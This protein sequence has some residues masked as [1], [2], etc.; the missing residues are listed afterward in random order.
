M[1]H[2]T[3][4]PSHTFNARNKLKIENHLWYASDVVFLDA[5]VFA[6]PFMILSFRYR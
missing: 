4:I 5:A 1:M 3:L 6:F 2:N